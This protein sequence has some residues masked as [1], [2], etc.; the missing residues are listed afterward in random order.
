VRAERKKT[1][2]ELAELE[3]F[4]FR[5]K[6][7]RHSFP[8][9]TTISEN[10]RRRRLLWEIMDAHLPKD[11]ENAGDAMKLLSRLFDH[12]NISNSSLAIVYSSGSKRK[13]IESMLALL[14]NSSF[15]EKMLVPYW[16]MH[17]V[18]EYG[19]HTPPPKIVWEGRLEDGTRP[20]FA[21]SFD[22][23]GAIHS[24]LG[25]EIWHKPELARIGEALSW[26][27]NLSTEMMVNVLSAINSLYSYD[28][29]NRAMR[30]YLCHK[31]GKETLYETFRNNLAASFS[32]IASIT[33]S[34]D[35]D[36][37]AS[38][39]M[40]RFAAMDF[41]DQGLFLI[42]LRE[43]VLWEK[44]SREV[45]DYLEAESCKGEWRRN[46]SLHLVSAYLG[47][48]EL[49]SDDFAQLSS[50][51]STAMGKLEG[52]KDRA[53]LLFSVFAL[54]RNPTFNPGMLKKY[55]DGCISW[56]DKAEDSLAIMGRRK[57]LK[58][59]AKHAEFGESD[60]SRPHKA[61]SAVWN[62]L[63]KLDHTGGFNPHAFSR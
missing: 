28:P 57:F 33:E 51:F 31:P 21:K 45:L 25:E 38:R 19:Q 11:P 36:L 18:L 63:R 7:N 1:P 35:F 15:E 23:T 29:R 46:A 27:R 53:L 4:A 52:G 44:I 39:L 9:L 42:S 40:R 37:D 48:R 20:Y 10:D 26:N 16:K 60:V 59:V 12:K 43:G 58:S 8:G 55:V 41:S 3:L 14:N 62:E 54:A 2:R 5:K 32:A 17:K 30:G 47:N 49:G 61:L 24:L 13:S 6:Y 50:S 56:A 34:P 22:A